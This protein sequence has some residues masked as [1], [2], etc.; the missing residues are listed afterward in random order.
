MLKRQAP[1][2]DLFV[3]LRDTGPSAVP[4][5]ADW[6]RIPADTFDATATYRAGALVLSDNSLFRALIDS[7]GTD[8]TNAAQW[9]PA[10]VLGNQYVTVADAILPV[11][12]LFDLDIGDLAV[13]LA[14]VR[15]FTPTGTAAAIEQTFAAEQGTLGHVQSRFCAGSRRVPTKSRSPVPPEPSSVDSRAISRPRRGARTGSAS[16]RSAGEPPTSRC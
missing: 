6:R 13:S 3:A 4:V 1:T 5:P 9:Q 14:T 2:F 11:S 7:P 8:L 12:S 15:V 16:S 10:G